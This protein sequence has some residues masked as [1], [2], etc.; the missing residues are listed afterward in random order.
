MDS[1]LSREYKHKH[2]NNIIKH[3]LGQ[4]IL[5]TLHSLFFFSVILSPFYLSR[6]FKYKYGYLISY[7]LTTT[8]LTWIYYGRCI[9]GDLENSNKY[10]S[11][12][13]FFSDILGMRMEKKYN[14]IN[15]MI[16]YSSFAT[17]LY[18]SPSA[19]HTYFVIALII[20]FELMKK[21]KKNM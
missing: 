2:N 6:S 15:I 9:L 5:I 10:G 8:F 19:F 18:Y 21:I 3:T 14:T 1:I 20:L 16:N 17:D 13:T 7:G 4:K 11:I 12:V